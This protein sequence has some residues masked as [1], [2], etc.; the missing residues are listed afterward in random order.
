M[1]GTNFRVKHVRLSSVKSE[2]A[3][4]DSSEVSIPKEVYTG[5]GAGLFDF[6]AKATLDFIN[7]HDGGKRCGMGAGVR[8]YGGKRCGMRA[9]VE[10]IQLNG[11]QGC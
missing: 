3:G 8:E 1:G 4:E 6:L 11:I 7:A 9:G 10:K 5:T 2:I